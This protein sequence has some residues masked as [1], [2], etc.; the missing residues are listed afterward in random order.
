MPITHDHDNRPTLPSEPLVDDDR[1]L[2][3]DEQVAQERAARLNEAQAI[4][5]LASDT[6]N[7]CERLVQ[8]DDDTAALVAQAAGLLYQAAARARREAGRVG[9]AV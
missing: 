9:R 4:E 7:I 1:P 2:T 3:H 8:T 5:D 6:A